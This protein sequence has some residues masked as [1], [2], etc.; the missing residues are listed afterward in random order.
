MT[1]RLGV[2]NHGAFPSK[3][4]GKRVSKDRD[5]EILWT[6]SKNGVFSIKTL[7]KVLKLGRQSV[8][9]TSVV[10]KLWVSSRVVFF[11][12]EATWRK[13]LTLDDIQR[14]G[15]SLVNRCFLCLNEEESVDHILLHCDRTRAL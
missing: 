3:T 12:W 9:P 14:R 11:I 15:W 7:N 2:G 10:W 6:E 13:V 8:F 4:H 5:D 1:Q